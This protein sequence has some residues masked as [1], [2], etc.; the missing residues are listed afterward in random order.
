[1][2]M[3]LSNNRYMWLLSALSGLFMWL[4]WPDMP[5]VF[6]LFI[7]FVP[8][9]LI[10]REV[11]KQHGSAGGLILF[12]HIYVAFLMW[13]ALTT[14]WVTLASVPGGLVAIFANAFLMTL[15]VLLFHKIRLRLDDRAGYAAFVAGWLAFEYL[16]HNWE[17][18]WPW[19][20]LG[21]GLAKF[22]ELVQWYEYTGVFGGSLW[23]LLVNLL[24]FFVLKD[25]PG[26]KDQAKTRQAVSKKTA[27]LALAT[28]LLPALAS[29][30]IYVG[31]TDEG[32]QEEIVI[33][34]PNIDPYADKFGGMTAEQQ[35]KR[36]IDMSVEAITPGTDYLVWPETALQFSLWVNRLSEHKAVQTLQ[37]FVARRPNMTIITGIYAYQNYPDGQGASATARHFRDGRCCYDAYNSAIQIDTSGVIAIYHKSKLVPGV[38]RMPYPQLFGFLDKMAIDLGGIT[39]SLGT[40]TERAVFFKNDKTGIAPVICYE[41]VFGAYVAEYIKNGANAIF[42]ITNDGWWGKTPGHR[43]HLRYASLRAIE[44]RRSIARAANTGISC[45]INQRGDILQA[46]RYGQ[47]IA[48]RGRIAIRSGLTIYARIGDVI[49][50]LASIIALFFML[51]FSL[52]LMTDRKA[53]SR[54]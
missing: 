20:T 19:L 35:F 36:L 2:R 49:G 30:L 18:T 43:Q 38:E 15:P 44:T 13:N 28:L 14:W 31:Y 8:I 3:K 4:G 10:E 51:A 41:S 42:I 39:G 40:Q 6:L 53:P 24:I 52:R 5:F 48:I 12:E 50:I 34:Q 33:V 1:M 11:A 46:T 7:G 22:P 9:L 26:K 37:E 17:L 23:V 16:H 47:K 32:E 25:A 27:I 29:A 45:F 54:Q 21:N